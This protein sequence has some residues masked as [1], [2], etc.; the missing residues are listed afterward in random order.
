[1]KSARLFIVVSLLVIIGIP[2]GGRWLRRKADAVPVQGGQTLVVV[3]PH[4]EQIRLEFGAAFDRW[5]RRVHGSPV[6]VDWRTPGGT[7]EIRKLLE[8]QAEAAVAAGAYS[9][10]PAKQLQHRGSEKEA[11]PEAVIDAERADLPDVFFGGGSFEHTASKVGIVTTALVD[12]KPQR[13]RVRISAPPVPAPGFSAEYLASVYGPE[14]RVG[15]E[16]LYDDD[17]HWF[18][19]AL[20]GFGIVYNR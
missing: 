9:I 10:V 16:R 8:S 18:G 11:L 20:S 4:I 3:T 2:V 1:M 12:G 7:S 14:N 5:H 17:Q 13:V 6:T 19:T 15:V